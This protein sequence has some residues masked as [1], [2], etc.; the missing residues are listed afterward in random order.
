VQA[1]IHAEAPDAATGLVHAGES[2]AVGSFA[3]AAHAHAAWEFY[4]Q[5]HGSSTWTVDDRTLRLAPGWLLAV[6]PGV[7]HEG[8]AAREPRGRQQFTYAALDLAA[9]GTRHPELAQAWHRQSLRCSSRAQPLAPAFRALVE[10]LAAE[11]P[12]GDL[13]LRAAV[14]LLVVSLA[15]TLL[16]LPAPEPRMARHPA[17]ARARQ[18]LDDEFFRPW[19]VGELAAAC[20]LSRARLAELFAVEV[21]QPPYEYLLERRVGRA[22]EL[23]STTT[24]SVSEVAAEVGFCSHVQLARRFRHVTGMSPREWRHRPGTDT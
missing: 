12:F 20:S 5:L 23:L 17:V 2:W 11:R 6:P 18:L 24:L 13:A 16:G 4:L 9:V 14:D 1:G 15:R 7:R 21:G 10:E 8:K 22:A 3:I 19:T